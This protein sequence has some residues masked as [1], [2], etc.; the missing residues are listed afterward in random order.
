MIPSGAVWVLCLPDDGACLAL[1]GRARALA[2]EADRQV[3][4]LGTEDDSPPER[5][6]HAGA[7]GAV[8]LTGA[9][10]DT[11]RTADAFAGILL[12]YAPEIVLC[13]ATV[14]GRAM[15]AWIAARL[16]TGLTAD[17]TAL[18]LT[19]DGFLLQTRPAFGGNLIADIL[20]RARRP[21]MASVRPGVFPP[22]APDTS[23]TGF[24]Q[25]VAC[26]GRI[27]LQRLHVEQNAE[28]ARLGDAEVI[29]A[30]GKGVGGKEGFAKLARLAALL[31]GVVGASRSA[32]DL[33]YAPYAAQIGL[34]GVTVRS[35]LYLAVGISGCVQHIAGMRGAKTVV[36]VNADRRAQIFSHADYGIV[37]DWEEVVDEMIEQIE[38]IRRK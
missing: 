20:C 38:K 37:G 34:T 17:C 32:V 29:V 22:P 36:A 26:E 14:E 12:R 6:F 27:F 5:Y 28:G 31:G 10:P 8:L 11:P 9:P 2:D 16:N 1:L 23:R 13:P 30:G 21:Q 15:S 24:V 4:A 33:G 18:S 19:Q 7:D 3:V 25:R 35:R